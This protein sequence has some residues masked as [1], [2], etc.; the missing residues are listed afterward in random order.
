[1]E[2]TAGDGTWVDRVVWE[3]ESP[4]NSKEEE[5]ERQELLT[6]VSWNV[7]AESYLTPRSHTHLPEDYQAVAFTPHERRRILRRT[8][9]H[10]QDVLR[11]DVIC[12]QE[13]DEVLFDEVVSDV[14]SRQYKCV[15]TPTERRVDSCAIFYRHSQW[16]LQGPATIIQLDDLVGPK[17][18]NRTKNRRN[19]K[20]VALRGM[21]SSYLRRN[22]AI[23]ASFQRVNH[24]EHRV[25]VCNCHLY[26]HPGYEYVKLSQAKFLMD[27]LWQATTTT[28]TTTTT[29]SNSKISKSPDAVLV[30]GDFNS[31]PGSV[32]HQFL[33]QGHANARTVA[34]WHAHHYS[35]LEQDAQEDDINN[36][37]DN[38]FATEKHVARDATEDAI[39][40]VDV[41]NHIISNETND[42]ASELNR[43]HI[44]SNVSNH[45]DVMPT[46]VI[47][48]N[49]AQS[50]VVPDYF[51]GNDDCDGTTMTTSGDDDIPVRYL[52]DFTL[53]RFTRWLRI[54]GIDAA[55]ETDQEEKERTKEGRMCRVE[56]RTLLTTSNRLLRRKD[57][58]P[59]TYLVNP[60]DLESTLVHL[61][62]THGVALRPHKFL[63]RCVVC[64]GL[65]QAVHDATRKARIFAT[66]RAPSSVLE[67]DFNVY[68]C[69]GCGQGYWWCER[70]TSSASRVKSQATRLFEICLVGGVPVYNED[71]Y[72]RLPDTN[73]LGFFSFV[74]LE[75]QR[76]IGD[77]K[78]KEQNT[79]NTDTTPAFIQ[80]LK[81][82]RLSHPFRL[83]SVYSDGIHNNNNNHADEDENDDNPPIRGGERLPFTNVTHDFVDTLD[84]I[85][86]GQDE[87]ELLDTLYVPTTFS[88]LNPKRIP[89][90]HLLPS[91]IWPSDHLAIG[92]RLAFRTIIE[93][94]NPKDQS[95]VATN[96]AESPEPE[97]K[98]LLNVYALKEDSIE[99]S[100]KDNGLASTFFCGEINDAAPPPPPP[101]ISATGPHEKRCDCGC[102]PQI[103]SLFQ[104]AELRKQLRLKKATASK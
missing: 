13:L 62:V 8:L 25:T 69:N 55:L 90:G 95:T 3:G 21:V 16:Q 83:K 93:P 75:K 61:L 29:T 97:P 40:P 20:T 103:L 65:I 17:P 37:D 63:T 14:L 38:A 104:M 72:K 7:L 91:D 49:T 48:E 60:N 23:L 26:W 15:S 19:D 30:C 44:H 47:L 11:V 88:E 67:D 71:Q 101:I 102:V 31:K 66:N 85:L 82:D 2:T 42:M 86:Y 57:C 33:T 10:F 92:A 35:N 46:N 5:E 89:N 64:N 76:A 51:D 77:A 78:R 28:T 70:P 50:N 98:D 43:M 6:V 84:Y 54:L 99:S 41:S 73:V 87:L 53:N 9:Q 39:V 18:K 22:A 32:V 79:T 68:Q 74:D 94:S 56:R 24:P 36:V 1:M 4:S 52:L 80:W 96:A 34:P 100:V 81:D 27:Q 12:L 45:D 58:P 59:G